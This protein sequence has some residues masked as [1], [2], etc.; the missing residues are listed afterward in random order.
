MLKRVALMFA[1]TAVLA[2][3]TTS[4]FAAPSHT[5]ANGILPDQAC[6]ALYPEALQPALC[7]R[8]TGGPDHAGG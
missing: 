6:F 2:I 1:A 8:G 3:P 5:T 7:G 4:A